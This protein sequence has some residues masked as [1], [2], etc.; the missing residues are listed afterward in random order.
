MTRIKSAVAAFV[1]ASL[2]ASV[3]RAEVVKLSCE[4]TWKRVGFSTQITQSISIDLDAGTIHDVTPF[5]STV[6]VQIREN[7]VSWMSPY[8]TTWCQSGSVDRITGE[9]DNAVWENTCQEVQADF[10]GRVGEGSNVHVFELRKGFC[11]P[12][13][14]KIF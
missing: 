3:V 10:N 4:V 12:A 2:N 6:N 5:S 7:R 9:F 13:S 14:K 1:A 11:I 8:N